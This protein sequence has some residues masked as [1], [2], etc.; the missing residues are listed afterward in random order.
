MRRLLA[1]FG[2]LCCFLLIALGLSAP[3]ALLLLPAHLLFTV[4]AGIG[5]LLEGLAGFPERARRWGLLYLVGTAAML[6]ALE[7]GATVH[8]VGL[9]YWAAPWLAALVWGWIPPVVAGLAGVVGSFRQR[10]LDR[11]AI[12]D[13]R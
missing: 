5:A 10:R 3:M 7:V 6:G 9:R 8:G 11:A 12:A 13:R 1:I 2:G 4:L